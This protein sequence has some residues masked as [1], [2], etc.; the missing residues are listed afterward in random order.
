[1]YMHI[2][3]LLP[4][5]V[6]MSSLRIS[7]PRA[8]TA[9][10]MGVPSQSCTDLRVGLESVASRE[11]QQSPPQNCLSWTRSRSFMLFTI[12]EQIFAF[13]LKSLYIQ[14]ETVTFCD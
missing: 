1:M 3:L 10:P 7:D 4:N 11:I 12:K 6:L 14:T 5:H 2:Y 9:M 13:C 8:H